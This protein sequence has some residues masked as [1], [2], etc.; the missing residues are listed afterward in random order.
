[1]V[2]I[3]N[4]IVWE[5]TNVIKRH[6]IKRDFMDGYTI[7]SHH[8][9]VGGTSNNTDINIGYDEVG[10]DEVNDND[11]VMMDDDYDRGDQNGDQTYVRVEPQVDEECD[12]DMEDMLHHFEPEVLIGSAKGLE[13]FEMLKK[14]AKDHM[15]YCILY[16]GEC[17]TLEKCPNCD[18]SRYK[19]NDDFCED[20]ASSSIGNKRKK[21]EKKSAGAYVE[22]EFCISTNMMTQC[23]VLA[24]VLWYLLVADRLKCLFSNP[25]IDEMMTWHA[26]RLGNVAN[27]NSNPSP[28]R[29]HSIF[30]SHEG[31]WAA[32]PFLA[33][34]QT[35]DHELVNIAGRDGPA[36]SLKYVVLQDKWTA[37]ARIP[38][39][40]FSSSPSPSRPRRVMP[41]AL[42]LALSPNI[43]R[44]S[45]R[46][47]AAA[48]RFGPRG[49]T[50]P[51]SS[52][53]SR[54]WQP[55]P[56]Q[57]TESRIR[58]RNARA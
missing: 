43:S 29:L 13:N 5:D 54:R 19:I 11:H 49:M 50:W 6:L 53:P 45:K 36:S 41:A 14:V 38:A 47:D 21:V 28:Y 48:S 44:T 31:A 25:K 56:G 9:E 26:D 58:M 2:S 55:K 4:K 35:T 40:W 16:R 18:A 46:R 23:R 8:G 30:D 57:E 24:L 33:F 20:R 3:R 1:M 7:W 27:P 51:T 34:D 39:A 15:N 32:W 10:G 17:A 42:P 12:V 22:D 37:M 52:P